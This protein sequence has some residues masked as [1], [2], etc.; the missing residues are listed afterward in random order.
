LHRRD[1]RAKCATLLVFLVAVATS[2]RHLPVLA[3]VWLAMLVA[4]A[5]WAR[6]P[7]LGLLARGAIV[8]PFSLA[9]AVVTWAA[10]DAERALA[11][12]LKSYLS[13]VAVLLV[14]GSTPISLL[15]RGLETAGAPRFL[16]MVTQ[17]LYRYLFVIGTEAQNMR[18]AS[19]SRGATLRGI[20]GGRARFRAAAGALAVLFARSYQRAE[21]IHRAMLARGFTG[22]IPTLRG[23]SYSVADTAF[24]VIAAALALAVRV[25]VEKVLG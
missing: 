7:A 18:T 4:T 6:L 24:L 16:L 19:A 25:G 23:L 14:V 10:G 22:H 3:A 17:F 9:F 20:V 5:L 13:V 15:L 1:P 11:L 21:D 2:H 12:V 8:L